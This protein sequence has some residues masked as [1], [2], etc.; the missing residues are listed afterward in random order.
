LAQKL[1]IYKAGL[2]FL[3]GVDIYDCVL[4]INTTEALHA[5]SKLRCTLGG[6]VSV[7]AGPVGMGGVLDTEVHKRQA[8]IFTYMKSRGFYAGVQVD[9]TIVIERTD[10]NARFYNTPDISVRDIMEGKVRHPPYET[11]RL[12][13]T[14][15]AAQGDTDIDESLLPDGPSPADNE[16][17]S[18]TNHVFG[19]PDAEDDDP[20]GVLALENAGVEI[21]EAGTKVRPSSDVFS[22]APSPSSPIYATFNRRSMDNRSISQWSSRRGSLLSFSEKPE[23]PAM[24][25]IS[26]QTDADGPASQT[27][28]SRTSSLRSPTIMETVDEK[29]PI[30]EETD[31]HMS[32]KSIESELHSPTIQ[33]NGHSRTLSDGINGVHKPISL[34]PALPPRNRNSEPAEKQ[35]TNGF[36]NVPLTSNH[37]SSK[38]SSTNEMSDLKATNE[39]STSTETAPFSP[40]EDKQEDKPSDAI[41]KAT[42]HAPE[43]VNASK[44]EGPIAHVEDH[45]AD[46][47]AE[48]SDDDIDDSAEIIDMQNTPVQVH[49]IQ[50]VQRVQRPQAPI[51]TNAGAARLVTVSKPVAPKLPPRSPFRTQ[52]SQ[53]NLNSTEPPTPTSETAASGDRSRTPSPP[54]RFSVDSEISARSVE[55]VSSSIAKLRGALDDDDDDGIPQKRGAVSSKNEV[56]HEDKRQSIPGAFD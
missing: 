24:V 49:K 13:E 21:K 43:V 32:M 40:K 6:E 45:N 18:P 54:K 5:F 9:G 30:G 28:V 7:A 36:V 51:V 23:K 55:S 15:K 33:I 16:I 42:S 3:V 38:A 14:I 11:R 39:V 37:D 47:D 44:E 56:V 19:V 2:G 41:E 46:A 25:D 31:K 4:V 22:F 12:L 48:L 35:F 10:E 17:A 52:R 8:P 27:S 53:L 1:T 26:T 29:R 34:P 50:S 20:Y